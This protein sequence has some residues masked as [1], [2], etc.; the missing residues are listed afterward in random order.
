MAES[1]TLLILRLEGPLQSW[2]EN[3][4]W[5]HRD[6]ADLPTKSG[7]IGL[8]GCALGLPRKDPAL[9]ELCSA[10][11]LAVRADRPGIRTT[12]YQTVTGTPLLNAEGKPKTTGNTIVSPRQYLQEACFTVFLDAD[13]G[14]REKIRAALLSPRW[15]LYLGRKSCVP[16]RPVL[17]EESDAYASL[18][19]AAN[20]YP[21]AD[22][23]IE[24]MICEF[25]R[26]DPALSSYLRP[27]RL[28]A[29]GRSF[30]LR[31]VWRGVRKEDTD[32]PE[33]N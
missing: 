29:P 28:A 31:R 4:K 17:A 2:G 12:D 8:L 9:V 33:Q 20:R 7:I 25:E 3:S 23:A 1:K 26:E 21:A 11:R 30:A 5:D 24:P 32:V 18:E 22:R 13:P 6:S 16:S 19:D 27:D 15:C 10:V 14:W